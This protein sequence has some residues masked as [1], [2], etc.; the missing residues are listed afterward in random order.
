M[1]TIEREMRWLRDYRV[2][3]VK[4]AKATKTDEG[5][6]GSYRLASS[7]CSS[8]EQEQQDSRMELAKAEESQKLSH[9]YLFRLISTLYSRLAV[10]HS[11]TRHRVHIET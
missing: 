8:H 3:A 1:W 7:Q 2:V 9:L 10:G 4:R 6:L 11:K 5:W